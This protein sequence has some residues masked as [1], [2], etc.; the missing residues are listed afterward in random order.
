MSSASV[1]D[2]V[3][4]YSHCQPAATGDREVEEENALK[5]WIIKILGLLCLCRLRC[6]LE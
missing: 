6:V 3:V 5:Y 2:I 1:I 4:D